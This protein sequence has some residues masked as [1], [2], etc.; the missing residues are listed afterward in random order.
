[1]NDLGIAL[2]W[3]AVQVGLVLAPTLALHAWASRRGPAAGAWVATAGLVMVVALSLASWFQDPGRGRSEPP[4]RSS[5]AAPGRVDATT[6]E[7]ERRPVDGP[8]APGVRWRLASLRVAWGILERGASEP[9][10]RCRPWGAWLAASAL[11]GAGLGLIRL[12]LGL[13]AVRACRRRSRPVDDPAMRALLDEL[14]AAMGR[15]R[16]VELRQAD[17]LS[18]PAAAGWRRPVILLPADWRSWSP[19]ERRAVLAHELA[20]VV[21]GDY[22]TALLA[23]L[24]VALHFCHPMVRWTAGRLLLQQEQAAD[25]LGARFAGGRASYLAALSRLALMQDGRSPGWAARGFL[26]GR[27]TLIRRIAMLRE[28]DETRADDRPMVGIRR[29]A[30]ALALASLTLGVASLRG[31]ARGDEPPPASAQEAGSPIALP[32]VGDDKCGLVA[33]RPAATFRRAGMQRYT[34]LLET[35]MREALSGEFAHAYG[36]FKDRP[37]PSSRFAELSEALKPGSAATGRRTLN[38]SEIELV[39]AGLRFGRGRNAEEGDLHAFSLGG[40]TIRMTAP[41]DWPEFLRQWGFELNEAHEAGRGYFRVRGPWRHILG[42]APCVLVLDDR[43]IVYDE[44]MPIV[45]ALRGDS[46]TPDYLRGPEWERASRGLLAV[47]IG[48]QDGAF[49]KQYDLGRPSDVAPLFQGVDRWVLGVDDADALAVRGVAACRDGEASQAVGRFID[50]A[51]PAARAE[52]QADLDRTPPHTKSQALGIG[53]L[54]GFLDKIQVRRADRSVE[55]V[56]DGFASLADLAA[57][58]ESE[59]A[60]NSRRPEAEKPA[61]KP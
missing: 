6:D 20:H 41:F 38:L 61:P 13:A 39:T 47:V 8:S 32:Y 31:P 11:A 7:G 43:T 17:D 36:V 49:A 35:A 53:V 30:T 26:A 12:A 16:T 55:L 44:E 48:N 4:P 46:P 14:A 23:R 1:M 33:F 10:E 40:A 24:A 22:A 52:W 2:A 29:V 18:G 21:R 15:A 3:L 9:A 37:G 25:A 28:Q 60:E 50:S 45:S 34:S 27:G 51:I 56:V 42:P 5:S 59:L 58:I 57:V 19:A 54:R